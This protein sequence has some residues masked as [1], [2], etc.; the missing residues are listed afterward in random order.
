MQNR[1]LMS[2]VEQTMNGLTRAERT[3]FFKILIKYSKIRELIKVNP[4]IFNNKKKKLI[5]LI[6]T[7]IQNELSNKASNYHRNLLFFYYNF[8]RI[9]NK[10]KLIIENNRRVMFDFPP[11][12]YTEQNLRDLQKNHPNKLGFEWHIYFE[13]KLKKVIKDKQVLYSKLSYN[14]EMPIHKANFLT[15]RLTK[16]NHLFIKNINPYFH[17]NILSKIQSDI[18]SFIG[19]TKKNYFFKN[20]KAINM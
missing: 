16:S 19:I 14:V 13:N 11:Q 1:N 3:H 7:I 10:K 20:E 2:F 4:K 8:E 9:F 15:P 12:I 5:K 18:S 6:Y 17:Y